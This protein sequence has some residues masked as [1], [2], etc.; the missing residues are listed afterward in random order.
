[1]NYN[2]IFIQKQKKALIIIKNILNKPIND[3]CLIEFQKFNDSTI[4]I[5]NEIFNSPYRIFRE[6]YL[7]AKLIAT[8]KREKI[9]TNILNEEE[10]LKIDYKYC[11]IIGYSIKDEINYIIDNTKNKD[12]LLYFY[13]PNALLG[14]KWRHIAEFNKILNTDYLL[15]QGSDDKIL[16]NKLNKQIISKYDFIGQKEWYIF[17]SILNKLYILKI[18]RPDLV[19][20]VGAGRLIKKQQVSEFN[21][22]IFN[23]YRLK[24]LDIQMNCLTI[25]IPKRITYEPICYSIKGNQICINNFT[26]IIQSSNIICTEL[27][28]NT[29]L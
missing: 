17:N 4:S 2:F 21:Y 13:T 16:L 29:I 18:K 1:M 9:L 3:C 14:L 24:S 11:N 27:P 26:K 10:N 5:T 19:Q 20:F 8:W 23:P 6:N 25:A 28:N 15:I 22:N 7:V 12:N